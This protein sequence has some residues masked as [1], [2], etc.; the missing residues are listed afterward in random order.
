MK[1]DM[2][3]GTGHGFG[4]SVFWCFEL[5]SQLTECSSIALMT[6]DAAVEFASYFQIGSASNQLRHVSWLTLTYII[7]GD[8]IATMGTTSSHEQMGLYLA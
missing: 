7:T 4:V 8:G 6:A 1:T 5:A 2:D 3:D